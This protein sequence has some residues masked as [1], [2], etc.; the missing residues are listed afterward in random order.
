VFVG[1]EYWGGMF[2]WI[3]TTML[4]KE[5]NISPED[6]N[7][8]RLVDTAEEATNHIFKFYEKYMLKPNF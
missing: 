7:L 5:K 4:D 8:Y 2:E 1:K 6:L 3:K